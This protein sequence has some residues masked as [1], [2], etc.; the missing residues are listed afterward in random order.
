MLLAAD[1]PCVVADHTKFG[2]NTGVAIKHFDLSAW[3]ITD[4]APEPELGAALKERGAK[5]LIAQTPA[6]LVVR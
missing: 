3:L 6:I 5:L 2:R 4:M 1:V